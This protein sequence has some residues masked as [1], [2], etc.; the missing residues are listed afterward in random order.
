MNPE[1]YPLF[2]QTVQSGAFRT[3]IEAIELILPEENF[4]FTETG[5]RMLA[6]DATES[7]L[8]SMKLHAD[9]FEMYR[10]ERPITVG[11]SLINFLKIIKIIGN[12]DT[13]TL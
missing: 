6:P 10:C 7:L 8:V 5:I 13:L 11:L 9:K 2:I 1:D 12:V 3:L 4:E